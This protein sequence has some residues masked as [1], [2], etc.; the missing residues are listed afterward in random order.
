[1]V[2]EDLTAWLVDLA[3]PLPSG[4]EMD[5]LLAL[6]GGHEYA[7][8]NTRDPLPSRLDSDFLTSTA[9]QTGVSVNALNAFGVHL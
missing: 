6:C 9:E 2:L 7:Y 1:V 4:H 3:A 8:K 5:G